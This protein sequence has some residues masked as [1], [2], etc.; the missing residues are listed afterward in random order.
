[1]RKRCNFLKIAVTLIFALALMYAPVGLSTA[2][3]KEPVSIKGWCPNWPAHIEIW[4]MLSQDLKKLGIGIDLKTAT[5]DEWVGEIVAKH[6]PYDLVIMSWGGGPER[7]EPSF[8]LTEFFHSSRSEPGGRN[9]GH[10]V[11]KEYDEIVDAQLMEMDVTKRQKL[12]RKAQELISRDNVFFPVFH[13]DYIQ[14]YN[15]ERIADAVVVMGTGVGFP[16]VP[17]T[18]YKAKPKTK[19]RELRVV[20]IHDIHTLNPFS[21]PD[22][23]NE[24]W[25]RMIYETFVIRDRDT[26][27]IPRAAESWQ[28]VDSTTVDIVLR[29]GMKFHDGMPVTVEDVKF[30]IDYIKKWKFPPLSRVWKNIESVKIMEGRRVRFK[31]VR[32]YAPF[33]ANILLHAFIAPK[34]IW[35]KIPESAGVAHPIDWPNP[36][37]IGSGPYQ[38]VEWKK[39]EYF[40]LKA[41]KDHWMA[42]NFDGLWYIFNPTIDGC[43][44]LLEKGQ[45]EIMGWYLDPKQAKDLD[46]LP[47]MKS[48]GAPN[49]GIHEL[50]PNLSMKP[51]SDPEF[52]RAFQHI[53]NRRAML[54]IIRG[55]FGTVAR[56]T[57]I[58]PLVKFWNNPDIPVVEY[59]LDKARQILKAAGYTWDEKGQLL[60]P[61]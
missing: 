3:S 21:T 30:T 60:Y 48:V 1:M 36:D 8:F 19:M 31:L 51:M 52:R 28:V 47:H 53:I 59:D 41:V 14:A 10:Y 9:Y 5:F 35:E 43:I 61:E 42:P 46:A 45:V 32:P 4:R 40:H 27:I 6:N 39:G 20:N 44:A 58:T 25:L 57:P 26:K 16:Y 11:N 15:V 38:F 18:F 29:E 7:L 22:V 33:V 2:H 24:G 34:H 13:S 56:N 54:D 17:W 49:H 23:E 12:V 55:G 37:A 50:R